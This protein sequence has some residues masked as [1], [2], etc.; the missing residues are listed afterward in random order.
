MAATASE[1]KKSNT[2]DWILFIVWT[3]IFLALLIYVPQWFWVVIP[4][5]LTYLVK[6]LNAM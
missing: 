2:T 4:F 1:N 5:P 3:I 6:A